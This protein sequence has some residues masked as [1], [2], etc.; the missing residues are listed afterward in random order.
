MFG[1]RRAML[2]IGVHVRRQ[3][4][5][6]SV[7]AVAAFLLLS[8]TLV[9]RHRFTNE[10]WTSRLS[11]T[12][13]EGRR[14]FEAKGCVRCHQVNGVG[15]QSGPDLG[16]GERE[17]SLPRLV[18]AMWNHAPKMWAR[19][20]TERLQYPSLDQEEMAHLFTYLYLSRFVDAPGDSRKGR[21][22]FEEKGCHE[23]HE[24]GRDPR[25]PNLWL[26][27]PDTQTL[28]WPQAMW[29][30]AR[31]MQESGERLGRSW[32]RFAGAEFSD[33]VAYVHERVGGK[34]TNPVV[35]ADP[36]KGWEVFQNKSC[37]ACHS[38]D[39]ANDRIGPDLGP[40]HRLP[41]TYNQFAAS[42]WNHSPEMFQAA[43]KAGI[44][45]PQFQGQEMANV[46]AFLYSLHYTDPSGSPLVG[47]SLFEWRGCARCHG[48][49][50]GGTELAPALRGR[51][52]H[53]TS[54][55]LGATLWQHGTKMH[56]LT[57][58]MGFAWPTLLDSDVGAVLAFLNEPPAT[59][60]GLNGSEPPK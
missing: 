5:T 27:K 41:P 32:P 3:L 38:L 43:Q 33:L 23:C 42:M 26:R 15:G 30:H 49:Q 56:T 8:A 53:F 21:T 51:G 14:L 44:P 45:R 57:Q 60:A 16:R 24:R 13:M 17:N 58:R 37:T 18:T 55:V 46:V 47:Q 59:R 4:I 39:G 28:A 2:E 1:L 25:A 36:G 19:I 34:S 10:Q 52:K 35:P 22:V 7:T 12:P 9:W 50:A 54:V 11:G 6:W 29:N 40:G 31:A 48:R 20:T